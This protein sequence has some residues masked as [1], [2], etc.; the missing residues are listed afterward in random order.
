MMVEIVGAYVD[1]RP[2]PSLSSF[3]TSDASVYRAGG[4]VNRCEPCMSEECTTSPAE[5]LGRIPPPSSSFSSS[6]HS[7]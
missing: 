1:G 7:T 5:R 3:L 6:V 2:I 4:R